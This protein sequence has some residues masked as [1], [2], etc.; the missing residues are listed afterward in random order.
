M[1]LEII[2]PSIPAAGPILVCDE[3]HN[4]IAEFYHNEHA[5]V[6]QSYR[7]ALLLAK[8]LVTA[9]NA[10]R[11]WLGGMS[12]IERLWNPFQ[13]CSTEDNRPVEL[14]FPGGDVDLGYFSSSQGRWVYADGK[15]FPE[16][17][18]PTHWRSPQPLRKFVRDSRGR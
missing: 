7:T 14:K 2:E 3:A 13:T 17:V 4:D 11:A 16:G 10:G 6:G 12:T 9:S 15:P 18:Y 5:T 8:A 1:K